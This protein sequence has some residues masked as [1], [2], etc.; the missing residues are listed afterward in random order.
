MNTFGASL[1]SGP[2]DAVGHETAPPDLPE[3]YA[4]LLREG[5][6]V[7][8]QLGQSLDGFIASRTGDAEFVT[9][10]EDRRHLHVLRSL[11]DAVVVGAATAVV[12]DCRLTVRDAPRRGAPPVRVVLDPRGILT[13]DARLLTEPDAPTLWFV[14]DDS[15]IG[16]APPTDLAPHVELA[17]HPE[18]HLREPD[19]LVAI[20]AERG[21]TR[22]LVEGGGR[23]VSACLAAGVLDRL[24]VTSAPVLI[25]DG[26]PGLRFTGHDVLAHALRPP[27]RRLVL[28]DDVCTEL[29][30]RD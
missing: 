16:A 21:F 18:A 25:G 17:A 13:R 19:S 27:S 28:G 29:R 7:V 15:E 23:L 9:G 1:P 8:A 6:L 3:F 12:D 14:A 26:I 30:L 5:P 20:L 4:P 22:V 10:P 2:D 11:V 24:Y